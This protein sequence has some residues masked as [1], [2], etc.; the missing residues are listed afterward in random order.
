MATLRSLPESLGLP[1]PKFTFEAPY[2]VLDLYSKPEDAV[3]TLDPKIL[4][5]FTAKEREGWKF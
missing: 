5:S 3:I 2:I 4:E 1:L